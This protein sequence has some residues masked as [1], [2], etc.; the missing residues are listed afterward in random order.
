MAST[1]LVCNTGSSSIKFA[2]YVGTQ[3]AQRGGLDRGELSNSGSA[4]HSLFS[5]LSRWSFDAIGHRI[6]HGGNRF[7]APVRIT[8]DVF[9]ELEQLIPLAPLHQAPALQLV[10]DVTERLPD[11]PQ[12]AC[13]DTAF[14]STMPD[15][16]K[17]LPLPRDYF[18]RGIR[19]F[20]FHGLSYE[21]IVSQLPAISPRATSG[22]T[23]VCHLGNGASLCGIANGQSVTTTMGFTPLDG[24]VMGT[25]PGRLDPGVVLHLLKHDG[26]TVDQV[27]D[28][29]ENKSGLLGVSGLSADMRQLTGS[30]T[31]EAADAVEMF[32]RSVAKEIAAAATVLGGLDA[33]V[34]TGGIGEQSP[35]VR[36]KVC[37]YLQWLGVELDDAANLRGNTLLHTT[38][39]RVEVLRIP[40]DEEAVIA[41]HTRTLLGM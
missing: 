1:V 21:S 26:L 40:S 39:S 19:R 7:S 35:V 16:E 38:A 23:V 8:A 24:L 32:C 5:A 25:R 36:A 34:F 27:E 3:L 22:K 31:P 12:V 41:K 29:L 30:A 2:V 18:A 11:V 4:T 20:G 10:R 15:I 37:S 14:H 9:S 17:R 6:V 28:L 13:F 33:I